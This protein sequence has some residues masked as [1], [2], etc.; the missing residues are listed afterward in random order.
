MNAYY[1]FM[2]VLVHKQNQLADMI[3]DSAMTFEVHNL[4]TSFPK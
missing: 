1:L 2:Q 3:K 4:K